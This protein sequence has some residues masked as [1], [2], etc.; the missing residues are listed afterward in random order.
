MLAGTG[1]RLG[2]SLKIRGFAEQDSAAILAIQRQCLGA[3]QW[4]AE[5]YA[6]LAG[7]QAGLVLVAELG[8]L[9]GDESVSAILVGFAAFHSAAPEAELRNL[10][11]APRYQRRGV[12]RALLEDAH[13]RLS[14][15]GARRVYLEVRPSNKPALS[16]YCS[17]GYIILSTR[18][19]YYPDPSEDAYV[20]S[21]E[22]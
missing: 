12:G 13:K 4:R 21:L 16:L 7:D 6:R 9:G 14:R 22:L 3:A 10:A 20:L 18:K 8:G 11:V 5:D 17:T 15:S 1:T 2:L 19:G